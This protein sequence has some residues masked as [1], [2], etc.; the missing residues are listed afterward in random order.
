MAD[1]DVATHQ[2]NHPGGRWGPE[3]DTLR[4]GREQRGGIGK[5]AIEERRKM[6]VEGIK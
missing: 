3:I 2:E 5:G 4:R 1:H 6:T